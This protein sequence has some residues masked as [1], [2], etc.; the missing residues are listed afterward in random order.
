MFGIGFPEML[1]ILVVALIA[2]GPSKLPDLARALGRGYAEFRKAMDELKETFDQDETVRGLRDEFRTAQRHVNSFRP[3]LNS[4]IQPSSPPAKEEA[5]QPP[6]DS[7]EPHTGVREEKAVPAEEASTAQVDET[8]QPGK[9]LPDHSS[10]EGA[11][12]AA[13]HTKH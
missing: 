9:E 11:T 5:P 8:R 12:A 3:S 13:G 7:T 1:V 10:G 6:P 4:L 2:V